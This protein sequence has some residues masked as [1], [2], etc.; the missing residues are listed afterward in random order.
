MPGKWECHW[1]CAL[2][3]NHEKT[4]SVHIVVGDT[5]SEMRFSKKPSP[6]AT[7]RYGSAAT[8]ILRL[9]MRQV[10]F[11]T[12][13]LCFQCVSSIADVDFADARKFSMV[14]SAFLQL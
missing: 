14:V 7:G 6:S 13:T 4:G 2:N 11:Q 12:F 10:R 9:Y 3:T 5:F 1:F 8:E